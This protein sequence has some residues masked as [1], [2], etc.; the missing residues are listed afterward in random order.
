MNIYTIAQNLED[1]LLQEENNLLEDADVAGDV[2]EELSIEEQLENIELY[3]LDPAT[4]TRS[5]FNEPTSLEANDGSTM[6]TGIIK[7]DGIPQERIDEL[8]SAGLLDKIVSFINQDARVNIQKDSLITDR[9]LQG[10]VRYIVSSGFTSSAKTKTIVRTATSANVE[11]VC[12]QFMDKF[13]VSD[14]ISDYDLN[15]ANQEL[16][17]LLEKVAVNLTPDEK[18][19]VRKRVQKTLAKYNISLIYLDTN[20]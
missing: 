2:V 4:N 16:Y 9:L 11:K 6:I 14:D 15:G 1:E 12:K 13:N 5:A 19:Q 18:R 10:V 3:Y 7:L 20:C 8:L 17:D